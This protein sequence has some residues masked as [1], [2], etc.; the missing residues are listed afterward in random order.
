VFGRTARTHV[1][2]DAVAS[3]TI[4]RITLE[5]EILLARR[6]SHISDQ[7]R[8]PPPVSINLSMD[9]FIGHRFLD[10]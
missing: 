1:V 8:R 6:H 9:G 10:G 4:Q 7:H 5:I 3:S 2:E